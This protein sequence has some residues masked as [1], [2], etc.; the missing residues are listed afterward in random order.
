MPVILRA[1]CSAIGAKL[2]RQRINLAVLE[3]AD[4]IF[5]DRDKDCD[6]LLDQDVDLVVNQQM[7]ASHSDQQSGLR[8]HS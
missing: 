6:M 4:A 1:D 7:R 2:H 8:R 3:V 5:R